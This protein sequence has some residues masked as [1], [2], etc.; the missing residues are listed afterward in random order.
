MVFGCHFNK[1]FY[2][3]PAWVITHLVGLLGAVSLM[4]SKAIVCL[5]LALN[6][7]LFPVLSYLNRETPTPTQLVY[8]SA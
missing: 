4:Q 8:I 7:F 3:E 5:L 2:S 6:R 1:L